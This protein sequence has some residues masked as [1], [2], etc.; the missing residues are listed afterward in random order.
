MKLKQTI[1]LIVLALALPA[2]LAADDRK[3]SNIILIMAGNGD[4]P[5]QL[6]TAILLRRQDHQV[7]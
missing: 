7:V 3:A 4:S 5:R 6:Q 2:S 1:L